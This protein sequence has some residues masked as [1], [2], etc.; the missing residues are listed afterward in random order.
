MAIDKT[1]TG[2]QHVL[3]GAERGSHA[4]FAKRRAREALKPAVA[5]KPCD[6]GL[7]GD[8]HAQVDLV[9]LLKSQS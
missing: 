2:D 6:H 7:F 1:G 3:P 4:E 9:N 8:H 5:Q